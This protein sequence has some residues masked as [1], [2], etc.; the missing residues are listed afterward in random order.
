[1]EVL[2]K[3]RTDIC[4]GCKRAIKRYEEETSLFKIFPKTRITCF[5]KGCLNEFIM[6]KEENGRSTP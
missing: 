6:I 3:D 1:M 4:N 5:N 2:P